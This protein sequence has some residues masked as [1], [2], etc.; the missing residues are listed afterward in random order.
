[1]RRLWISTS[2]KELE[3]EDWVSW[4]PSSSSTASSDG[5]SGARV[6]V[7]AVAGLRRL[8]AAVARG[9]SSQATV[10]GHGRLWQGSRLLAAVARLGAKQRVC[11]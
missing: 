3:V 10:A 9:R 6:L 7:C 2:V 8:L 5:G 11:E 1:M 4:P